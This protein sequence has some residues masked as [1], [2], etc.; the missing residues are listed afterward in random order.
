M[1]EDKILERIQRLLA[2][3]DPKSGAAEQEVMMAMERAQSMLADHN[4][5]LA[6]VQAHKPKAKTGDAA[7][8]D[9][10]IFDRSTKTDSRPWRRMFVTPLAQYYFTEVF[11]YHEKIERDTQRKTK[12]SQKYNYVRKDVWTFVGARHNVEVAKHMFQYIMGA[13]ERLAKE[14]AIE[15]Q[16]QNRAEFVNSFHLAAANRVGQR[17]MAR[18]HQMKEQAK[19]ERAAPTTPTPGTE[20]IANL[21]A[22]VDLYDKTEKKLK[23]AIQNMLGEDLKT[24][25]QRSRSNSMLGA[26]AG[27]QAG[28]TISLDGQISASPGNLALPRPRGSKE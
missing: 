3:A 11:F 22:I 15:Y 20:K 6:Q 12:K 25:R 5:S 26:A 23:D 19:R 7:L 28:D 17:I 8:D 14:A 24:E 18:R 13:I 27:E 1:A 9:A 16:P 10:V 21:P 4:L 2:M